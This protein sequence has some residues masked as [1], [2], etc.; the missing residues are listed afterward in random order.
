ME[1]NDPLTRMARTFHATA[2]KREA[3]DT[4]VVG[5]EAPDEADLL[6]VSA[7]LNQPSNAVEILDDLPRQLIPGIDF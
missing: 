1:V 7:E 3:S 4:V 5:A 2:V 6:L